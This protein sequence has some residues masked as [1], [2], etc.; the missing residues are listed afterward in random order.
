M[1]TPTTTL[2][3]RGAVYHLHYTEHGIRKRFSLRTEDR[4]TA[5]ELQRQFESARVRGGDNPLPTRTPLNQIL[6]RFVEEMQVRLTPASYGVNSSYLRTLFGRLCPALK[7]GRRT[8]R[9][10]RPGEDARE[11]AP[12]IDVQDHD[13][14]LDIRIAVPRVRQSLRVS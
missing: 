4:E 14:A 7:R 5:L 1:A 6:E 13:A 12:R 8:A 11:N 3:R 2:R 9:K 10:Y